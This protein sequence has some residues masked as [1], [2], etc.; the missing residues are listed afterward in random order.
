[1]SLSGKEQGFVPANENDKEARMITNT[2]DLIGSLWA[3]VGVLSWAGM[4]LW[5]M[6]NWR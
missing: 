2:R 4:I 1:L 5:L 3:I 6:Y